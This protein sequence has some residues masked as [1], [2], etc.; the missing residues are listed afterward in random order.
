[1]VV[2][3]E[4]IFEALVEVPVGVGAIVKVEWDFDGAGNYPVVDAGADGAI[5][6]YGSIVRHAFHTPGTYCPRSGCRL[7]ARQPPPTAELQETLQ[8]E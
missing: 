8:D 6:R 3:E 5:D 4:V 1:V 7:S 2:G